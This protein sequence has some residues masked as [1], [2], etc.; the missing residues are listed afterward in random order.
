MA[1]LKD[2]YS[3]ANAKGSSPEVTQAVSAPVLFFVLKLRE[4]SSLDSTDLN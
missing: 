3:F 4:K 2:S 1:T